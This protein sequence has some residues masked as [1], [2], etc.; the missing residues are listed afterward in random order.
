MTRTQ[1]P[2]PP[3]A[4]AAIR[5]ASAGDLAALRAFFSG[6]DAM[7]RYRRFFAAITPS[8]AMLTAMT[9]DGDGL[10]CVVAACDSVIVGHAMAA[11]RRQGPDSTMTAD[12]GV[13]VADA[14]QGHGLGSALMRTLILRAQARGVCALA[15]DVLPANHQVLAMI[16]SHWPQARASRSADAI[17]FSVPLGAPDAGARAVQPVAPSPPLRAPA[18]LAAALPTG[19]GT[20]CAGL[21]S[22]VDSS[23][24]SLTIC[25]AMRRRFGVPARNALTNLLT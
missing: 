7:T 18:T 20:E 25:S 9:G 24:M 23:S 3:L 5:Q 1:R 16:R 4:R 14:W 8:A 17:V 15:M 12:I 2:A 6:L 10:D 11:D 21:A 13:V 19:P 22:N